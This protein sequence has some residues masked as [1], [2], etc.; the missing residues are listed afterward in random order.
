[1]GK[2]VDTLLLDGMHPNDRGHEIV[3]DMLLPA[4]CGELL[5]QR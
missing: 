4:I 2:P 3:A 5:R 1:M